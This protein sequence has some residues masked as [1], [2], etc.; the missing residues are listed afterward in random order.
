MRRHAPGGA[1][2]VA[3]TVRCTSQLT[4]TRVWAA[5]TSD[6]PLVSPGAAMVA[7]R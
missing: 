1:G 2:G 3:P 5:L 6:P 7:G 4:L